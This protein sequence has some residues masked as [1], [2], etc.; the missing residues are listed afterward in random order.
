MRLFIQK[1]ERR[2]RNGMQNSSRK[3]VRKLSGNNVSFDA[4]AA[5]PLLIHSGL[6]DSLSRRRSAGTAVPWDGHLPSPRRAGF[7][8][9]AIQVR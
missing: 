3:G 8:A 7:F 1:T 2:A 6:V 9:K 5:S 4:T